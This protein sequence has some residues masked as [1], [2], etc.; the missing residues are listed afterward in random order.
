MACL[1]ARMSPRAAACHRGPARLQRVAHDVDCGAHR[2]TTV[3][4]DRRCI[5]FKGKFHMFRTSLRSTLSMLTVALAA[6]AA[7]PAGA[8]QQYHSTFRGDGFDASF[9]TY[10]GC[11]DVQVYFSGSDYSTKSGPGQ[12]QTS[13]YLYGYAWMFDCETQSW[14]SAYIDQSNATIDAKGPNSSST[15]RGS[16]EVTFGH[17]ELSGNVSCYTYDGW[18]WTDWDGNDV[19]E[20]GGEYCYDE[21]VWVQDASKTLE[22][23]LALAP[24]GDTYR[25]MSMSMSKGPYGMYRSRYTGSQR[26][27]NVTGSVTVDGEE[28]NDGVYSY[29]WA[30]VW[31]ATSGSTVVY[32]N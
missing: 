31:N 22:V 23:D 24:T 26:Y 3:T 1:P 32:S 8:A 17:W 16:F 4:D 12:P 30:N 19:C 11:R 21:W 25:G 27:G 28:L 18:C 10:D 6:L 7:G 29:S 2:L 5:R 20:P 15:L 14:G 9:Y 13:N